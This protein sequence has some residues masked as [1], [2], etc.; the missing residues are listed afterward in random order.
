MLATTP[1][2][3]TG[4][5][6]DFC[7]TIKPG[8]EPVYM[9]VQPMDFATRDHC[10]QNVQA[11]VHVDGGTIVYG[12]M[13]W[14]MPNVYIE[15]EHHA[16]YQDS[17]G[18]LRDVTPKVHEEQSI[19]FLR[20][21]ERPYDWVDFKRRDNFRRA[22][23]SHPSVQPYLDLAAETAAVFDKHSREHTLSLTL[24][25]EMK[26]YAKRAFSTQSEFL[27]FAVQAD[28]SCT[29]GS[30]KKVRKCCGLDKARHPA[31]VLRR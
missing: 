16:V 28:S 18:G 15:A 11:V 31:N 13:I 25:G 24:D 8:A 20:D 21:D 27:R 30:G 14:V 22:L 12:W 1:S 26:E 7:A 9:A 10:F 23:S 29:C 6:R 2:K 17:S 5:V 4:Q 3:I 19:L